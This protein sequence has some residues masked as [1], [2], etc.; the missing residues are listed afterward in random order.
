MTEPTSSAPSTES[1][2]QSIGRVLVV[3]DQEGIRTQLRWGLSDRFEVSVA[4]TPDE[5]RQAIQAERFDAVT[6][7]LGL[8]PDAD[9]PTEGLR[10]L[11]EFLAHD[12]ATKVVVLTGNT[13]HENAIRAV[14]M[15]AYDYYLKPVDVAELA[16]I[17][18]APATY[19]AWTARPSGKR[20]LACI[21]RRPPRSSARARRCCGSSRRS[22]ESPGPT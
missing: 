4:G 12:P 21:R 1:G 22:G 19:P 18:N 2:R 17:L 20:P 3:D 13:D 7:D 16:V 11:E 14:Q 6:L 8:P 15:G 5:A 9:G 10:L